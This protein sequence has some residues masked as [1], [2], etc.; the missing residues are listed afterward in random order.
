MSTRFF[1]ARIPA[2]FR[3]N[4]PTEFD[5][6]INL[7]TA[8]KLGL[9]VAPSLLISARDY[10]DIRAGIG[11]Y[12]SPENYGAFPM[13]PYSHTPGQGGARQPGLTGQV[14]EDVICRFGELGVMVKNGEIHFCP[15]LLRDEEFVTRR[16]EYNYYGLAGVKQ[17][18][19]L[20]PGEL[21]FT[22]CQVPVV[23][24][25]ARVNSLTLYFADGSN[26]RH[27]KLQLDAE[28]SRSLFER[29]G[30]I[31]RIEVCLNLADDHF[32]A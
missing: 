2:I 27:E 24:R 31:Q 1:A 11:D 13:D 18:L 16:T 29:A 6:A 20:K 23:F 26:R 15:R 21:G 10:Y 22:Y 9:S 4:K 32:S 5:L 19:L 14:K 7:K 3:C 28:S 12:K 8:K 17:Q 30:T 25:R